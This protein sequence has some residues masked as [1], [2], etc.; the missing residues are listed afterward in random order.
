[1]KHTTVS[2]FANVLRIAALLLIA[3]VAG[4]QAQG[5]AP[6]PVALGP[7]SVLWL[8][9]TSTMHDFES[10]STEV[11]VALTRDPGAGSPADAAGLA[12]LMGASSIRGVTVRVPVLSLKSGKEGLDKNLRKTMLVDKHPEVLFE[13]DHYTVASTS[14]DTLRLR[15]E[16]FLTVAGQK[17]PIDLEARAWR[18]GQGV[19]LAGHEA[20]RMSD[21]GMKPPRM[22]MGALRVG[23]DI[24][25]EYKLLLT[26]K[27]ET[28]ASS[29]GRN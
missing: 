21:F 27:D 15:A 2:R 17:R 4:G 3:W 16:G 13:L 28:S 10:R 22:M 20:L 9:G 12:A 19:W 24:R 29:P 7:G 8:E 1:M 18:N 14:G 25:V 6:L 5:T 11:K 23:D 26:P